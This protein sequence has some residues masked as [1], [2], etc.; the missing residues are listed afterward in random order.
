[1]SALPRLGAAALLVAAAGTLPGCSDSGTRSTGLACVYMI[2]EEPPAVGTV[3]E[4]VSAKV[5][6]RTECFEGEVPVCR[7]TCN[8]AHYLKGPAGWEVGVN[9]VAPVAAA[10]AGGAADGGASPWIFELE[11][12]ALK[13]PTEHQFIEGD[14]LTV[15]VTEGGDGGG[16]TLVDYHET[17]H[18][19]WGR[20]TWGAPNGVVWV[21]PNTYDIDTCAAYLTPDLTPLPQ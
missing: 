20:P 21:P 17:I 1:M 9:L 14:R 8:T 10:D 11:I 4:R 13:M 2:R 6:L 16:A 15:L 3:A 18:Y 12:L 5:C 19:R 7:D